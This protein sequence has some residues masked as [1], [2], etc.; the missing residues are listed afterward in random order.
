MPHRPAASQLSTTVTR[1][2]L[3]RTIVIG[4]LLVFFPLLITGPLA[5]KEQ[6]ETS[7]TATDKIPRLYPVPA[8]SA[9]TLDAAMERGIE[10]LLRDQNK[11]GSWG[12]PERTKGLNI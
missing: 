2:V 5:G 9:V 6:G 11:D 12:T 8:P 1:P 10:F 7:P 4:A 3:L